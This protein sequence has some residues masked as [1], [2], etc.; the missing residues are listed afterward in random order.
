MI[1]TEAVL[2]QLGVKRLEQIRKYREYVEGEDPSSKGPVKLPA[3]NQGIMGDE[4]FAEQIQRAVRVKSVNRRSYG[5]TEIVDAVC[6]VAKVEARE[7]VKP[8]RRA[9][10]QTARELLMYIARNHT[11]A[12]LREIADHLGVRDIS[13][14]SHGVRRVE[15][16]LTAGTAAAK[17]L[18]RSLRRIHSLIQA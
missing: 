3:M 8:L 13:T 15:E 7:L 16:K 6:R 14:V 17:E 5:L 4:K 2:D 9:R 11:E 18:E 12:A 10:V 1:S